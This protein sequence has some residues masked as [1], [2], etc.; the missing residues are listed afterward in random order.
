MVMGT[1]K[2]INVVAVGC[3]VVG[4]L[5]GAQ[6]RARELKSDG[7][8]LGEKAEQ[9]FL[10]GNAGDLTRACQAGDWKGVARIY[11]DAE[12]ASK[13]NGK[14]I[15]AGQA[16]AKERAVSGARVEYKGRSEKEAMRRD[17][18]TFDGGRLVKLEMT[19]TAPIADVEGYHPKTYGELFAGLQEAYGAP[20]KSYTEPVL[21][22]YGVRYEAHRAMWMG[23][24]DVISIVEQPG[25]SGWTKVAA[26]T[27]GEY[28]RAEAGPKAANPLQ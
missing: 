15:C 20:T 11:K 2:T 14:E 16:A 13:L 10:E 4:G 18:F 3:L 28:R 12:H 17:V 23:G 5:A 8:V 26:V 22:A 25:E 21:N 7:H 1:M 27:V 19:Y 9:F 24:D 6:A